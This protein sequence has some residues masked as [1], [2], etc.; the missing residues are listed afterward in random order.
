MR[1]GVDARLLSRPLTGMGR[2]TLEMCRELLNI[3]NASLYI[4]SPAPLLTVHLEV[5]QGAVV[6]TKFWNN[7]VLRQ[8][9]SETYLPWWAKQDE[10]DVF[11]GPVHR[12]PSFLPTNIARRPLHKWMH[13]LKWLYF[14][15]FCPKK[16]PIASY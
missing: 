3:K 14:T 7:G 1:I 10:I 9:W 13:K 8:I 16:R 5:M 12:L 4:Y 11:W 15:I 6:R 2:Y